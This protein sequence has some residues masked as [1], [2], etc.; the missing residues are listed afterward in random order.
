M[1]YGIKQIQ[2][3]QNNALAFNG[4]Q[5]QFLGICPELTNALT[6]VVGFAQRTATLT[7]EERIE[8]RTRLFTAKLQFTTPH[9]VDFTAYSYAFV[10]TTTE[11]IRFLIGAQSRPRVV[12]TTV[13]SQTGAADGS[14]GYTTTATFTADYRPNQLPA[15]EEPAPDTRQ[16]TV[17]CGQIVGET[18]IT[19]NTVIW[20]NY[21]G[22]E[23]DRKTYYDGQTEPTTSV[24]PTKPST[25]Q[26]SYVFSD[27]ELYSSQNNTKIY[28]PVFTQTALIY[29][30]IWQNYDGTEVAREDYTYGEPEPTT[31]VVPTRP[32]D[33]QYSY[34]FDKWQLLSE[35]QLTKTYI[36][37][38]TQEA[39]VTDYAVKAV[40]ATPKTDPWFIYGI[41]YGQYMNFGFLGGELDAAKLRAYITSY[42]I[43]EIEGCAIM[44]LC[45]NEAIGDTLAVPSQE[46][47][48]MV[49]N[50]ASTDFS[51]INA[52]GKTAIM[53]PNTQIQLGLYDPNTVTLPFTV[54]KQTFMRNYTLGD[55]Y[56]L[57]TK[58]E[59]LNAY[60]ATNPTRTGYTFK[61]W[62][63]TPTGT[64]VWPPNDN[65]FSISGPNT[66]YA[67][68][69]QD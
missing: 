33:A 21:D 61:G 40:L 62:A 6:D 7:I 58:W 41:W 32:D 57:N 39:I 8:N 13:Q 29:T 1:L 14:T 34:T 25:E 11:G 60:V 54:Y 24:V 50:I 17:C 69:E 51:H 44:F 63:L 28:R 43:S 65:Y 30:V 48:A 16:F 31:S 59:N 10:V 4:V 22:T 52:T 55:S 53:M 3:C 12:V 35:T 37:T 5:N 38:Y 2:Y 46:Y 23:L 9:I 20:Q 67:I 45:D 26:Y 56:V 42:H 64:V 68:W 66:F 27:W 49:A 36:A 19:T 18:I 47:Y 15:P